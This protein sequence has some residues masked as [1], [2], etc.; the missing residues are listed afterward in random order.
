VGIHY[1]IPDKICAKYAGENKVPTKKKLTVKII[2]EDENGPAIVLIEGE[3]EALEFLGRLLLSQA[4]FKLDCGFQIGPKSAGNAL[5]K[6][7]STHGIYIHR[8][9]CLGRKTYERKS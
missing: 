4:R 8:L 2:P 9:P 3:Q 5:F 7:N 1:M 6:R